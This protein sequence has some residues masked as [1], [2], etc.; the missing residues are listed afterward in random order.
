MELL[1]LGNLKWSVQFLRF[2]LFSSR[3]ASFGLK[4]VDILKVTIRMFPPI[5][6]HF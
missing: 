4:L 3:G 2:D 1:T 6:T 5:E